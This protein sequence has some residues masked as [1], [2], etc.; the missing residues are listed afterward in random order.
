MI[1]FITCTEPKRADRLLADL[2]D[3]L[4]VEGLPVVG[5]VLADIEGVSPC[6]MHLRLLPDG[7]VVGI[8]QDL[9]AGADACTL[10][11][12]ALEQAVAMV[13]AHLAQVPEG[14]ILILNKFGKQEADGRGCRQLIAQGLE[15]GL[16]VILSAPPETRAMFDV[17]AADFATEIPPDLSA[18]AAFARAK[19]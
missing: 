1:G 17:F 19:A 10:D 14:A 4:L 16:R 11:A 12:G 8:S 5:M 13:G 6:D 7:P 15:A 18:L 2:A 3:M 9:G